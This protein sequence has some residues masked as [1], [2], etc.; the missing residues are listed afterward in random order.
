MKYKAILFDM[1]GTLLPM[2]VDY[3]TRFYFKILAGCLMPLGV[4]PYTLPKVI[5]GGVGAMMKNDGSASNEKVFWDYFKEKTGIQDE[6]LVEQINAR[7]IEFYGNEFHG[8]KP[9]TGENPLAKAAVLAAAEAAD[10]VVLA[11]NPIFPRV[12]QE[13]RMS[14]IGVSPSDF[15]L[16]TSYETDCFAKPNPKY[17]LSVCQR[18]GVD[19]SECLVIGNDEKEDMWCASHA[20]IDCYLVTDSMIPCEEHPWQGQRGTFAEMVEMLKS[21]A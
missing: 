10:H 21:L 14:W 6:K 8:A 15:E 7:C 4:D 13:S 5:M 3:F 9:A 20:G 17:F 11:T 16:I 19:P 18:I 12:A 1:D 2:D